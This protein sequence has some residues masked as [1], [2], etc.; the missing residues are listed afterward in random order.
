M[1]LFLYKNFY[2][3][4]NYNNARLLIIK[5]FKLY[6]LIKKKMKFNHYFI[7]NLNI[8]TFLLI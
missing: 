6:Q 3:K 2:Y 8:I 7:K 5:N 4:R 1:S